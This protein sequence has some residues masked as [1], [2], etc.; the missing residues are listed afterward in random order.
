MTSVAKVEQVL[1]SPSPT[2]EP[3]CHPRRNSRAHAAWERLGEEQSPGMAWD[4]RSFGIPGKAGRGGGG[5][6]TEGAGEPCGPALQ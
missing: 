1:L 3:L 2:G 4:H 6:P 5:A